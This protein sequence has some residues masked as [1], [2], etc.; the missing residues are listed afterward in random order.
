MGDMICEQ[1]G[2]SIATFFSL[3]PLLVDLVDIAKTKLV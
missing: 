1:L 2:P 3:T